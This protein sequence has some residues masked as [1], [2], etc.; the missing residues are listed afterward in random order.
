MHETPSSPPLI[1]VDKIMRERKSLALKLLRPFISGYIK[2]IVHQK[3]LNDF[4]KKHY[5]DDVDHFIA[6]G[7]FDEFNFSYKV[8]HENKI[9]P[10]PGKRYIY[11]SNHPIGGLDGILLIWL[12]KQRTGTAKA[13]S[14]DLLMNLKN[15]HE[16]FI[17]LNLYGAKSRES[18]KAIH[19]AF[20][21]NYQ[22][23]IFPA[24]LVSRRQ[25]GI[26]KDLEWKPFFVKQAR[27]Y[28]RDII[29]V[30]ISGGLSNFFYTF[31]NLRKKSGIKPNIELFYL[32]NETFK[33]KNQHLTLTFGDPVPY[34]TFD[35][36]HTDA[37]WAAELREFVYD[38]GAG[39]RT[40]Y[41]PGLY[42][43]KRANSDF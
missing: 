16:V 6:S 14:N 22:I 23:I 29:P 8:V 32:P 39:K 38:L 37:A 1:D 28:Q 7:L 41:E 5:Q 4:L 2:K 34:Q 27:K 19:E 30:H 35:K 25:K 42:D 43:E 31:A 33:Q 9:F 18:V 17:G 40:S 24:G 10:E 12:V 20:S 11:V 36:S 3:E 13:L 26:V 21:G 15:L